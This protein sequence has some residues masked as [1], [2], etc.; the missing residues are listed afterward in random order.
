MTFCAIHIRILTLLWLF[1]M[2]APSVSASTP[3]DSI[4]ASCPIEKIEVHRLP[5]LNVPR[6]G[7]NVF[8]ANGEI[9]VVGGHTDGFIP[10]ATAE[11]YKEGA[12]HLVNT[13]YEHDDSFAVV[14]SSGKVLIAGGHE[15][16]LGIGQTFVAEMYDPV[17]HTFEG[18][19]CMDSKRSLASG[20]EIDNGR[21]VIAGNHYADDA[22]EC[23]DGDKNFAPVKNVTIGRNYPYILRIANDDAII[24]GA[25]NT[26][27]E[28]ISEMWVDRVKSESFRVPLLDM[29][30][31]LPLT[32]NDPS[33]ISSIGDVQKGDYS[34]LLAAKNDDGQLAIV[35]VQDTIFSLLPTNVAIPTESQWGKVTY[36]S[37]LF[38]DRNA[39]KAYVLG[40]DT[41]LRCYVL[42]ID[43]STVPRGGKAALSLRYTDP[44]PDM[45]FDKPM[46]TSDGD[47]ILSGGIHDSNF[48]PLR[49]VFLLSLSGKWQDSATSHSFWSHIL[50]WITLLL[51]FALVCAISVS[52]RRRK[53]LQAQPSESEDDTSSIDYAKRL[54]QSIDHAMIEKQL[55]LNSELKLTD[56]AVELDMTPR[57]LAECIKVSEGSSF[58]QYVN[59][60]RVEYAKRLLLE[61]PEKKLTNVAIESG[62][63]NETSFFRTFK[64]IT[65][66]TPREWLALKN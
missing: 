6:A 31:P 63:A 57:N 15:K 53:G 47:I 51:I 14:L 48:H 5:D 34:Y 20:T 2:A 1:V 22:I 50:P 17:T 38:S 32:G 7:H 37:A 12:W 16:H 4:S 66:T 21:V 11:Y 49:S 42:C 64:S 65:G 40:Y 39:H 62:F 26:K 44:L 29:W 9:I 54:M 52:Y 45:G 30:H 59:K 23:F 3:P 56:V 13:V 55:F 46:L 25:Y 58:A 35:L 24:F 33:D 10:T 28:H 41:D 18:F 27:Y 8:C 36:Y 19:G 43:Y 60:Y 61:Q